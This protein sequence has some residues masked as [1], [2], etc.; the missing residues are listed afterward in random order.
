MH[1]GIG[2]PGTRERVW[3]GSYV[4]CESSANVQLL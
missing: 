4:E 3:S 2:L 1:S